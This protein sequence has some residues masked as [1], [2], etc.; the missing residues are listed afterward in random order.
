MLAVSPKFI[1]RFLMGRLSPRS[2]VK[3]G[4]MEPLYRTIWR[5][6]VNN[7][8]QALSTQTL[9]HS[10]R[11]PLHPLLL[12]AQLALLPVE[13]VISSR[14][15]VTSP[16]SRQVI[17]VKLAAPVIARLPGSPIGIP[18]LPLHL[19]MSK[20]VIRPILEPTLPTR[21]PFVRLGPRLIPLH[22][23][24]LEER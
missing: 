13:L 5:V 6:S 3:L 15:T 11:W 2:R 22:P 18:V 7:L 10:I 19:A 1:H 24:V 17:P 16:A 23:T 4:P 8:L 12:Q 20:E 21:L 9:Q 14:L